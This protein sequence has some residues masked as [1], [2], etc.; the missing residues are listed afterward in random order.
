LQS[1]HTQQVV[2][3]LGVTE[4]EMEFS[5]QKRLM[6]QAG[7]SAVRQYY[8]L[9]ELALEDVSSEGGRTRQVNEFT[10]LF[11]YTLEAGLSSIVVAIK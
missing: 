10:S 1:E 3:D 7:F 2:R 4:K 6:R 8:R 11:A 9:S 5:L